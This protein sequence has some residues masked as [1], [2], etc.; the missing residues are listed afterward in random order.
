MISSAELFF[1]MHFMPS[2]VDYRGSEL[3]TH[4]YYWLCMGIHHSRHWYV[5]QTGNITVAQL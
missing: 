4:D 1:H 5:R 3:I 2:T